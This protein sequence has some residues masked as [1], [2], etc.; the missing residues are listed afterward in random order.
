MKLIAE[1]TAGE[2]NYLTRIKL[3]DFGFGKRQVWEGKERSEEMCI[4]GNSGDKSEAKQM[5]KPPPLLLAAR[6]MF[7]TGMA[8]TGSFFPSL[9]YMSFRRL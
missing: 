6:E 4:C 3:S 2:D 1:K 7:R 8:R 5:T 9:S